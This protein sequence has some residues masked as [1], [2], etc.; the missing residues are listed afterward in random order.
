M[1]LLV[2]GQ[3]D[4]FARLLQLSDH[5]PAWMIML[6][7]LL[8]IGTLGISFSRYALWLILVYLVMCMFSGNA[9]RQLDTG[10]TLMRWWL[11]GC[12][13]LASLHKNAHPGRV[14]IMLGTY[15]L[16]S[17]VSLLWSPNFGAG[18]QIS[19]LSIA[20]ILFAGSGISGLLP[21]F[22]TMQKIPQFYVVASS[23][24]AINAIIGFGN[25]EGGRR[26]SGSSAETVSASLF[27]ITGG[28]LMPS[29]I[30]GYNFYK[31]KRR[32]F[33]LIGFAV[34]FGLCFLSGQRTG[35]YAGIAGSLAFIFQINAKMIPRAIIL[36][37]SAIFFCLTL[38]NYF[39][40]QASFI[41][42]RTIT[43]SNT[44]AFS[45]NFNTTGRAE[46]WNSFFEDIL[47]NPI[48]GYGASADKVRGTM[49][50]HN[51][52]LQEWYN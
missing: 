48:I 30:W 43:V 50:A 17:L 44:N 38:A 2:L 28:L 4:F 23:V 6:G 33:S 19:C 7:A 9:I 42:E 10:S 41:F 20:M 5:F 47:D 16:F 36:S 31:G 15:W 52:Y 45:L 14:C 32:L 34:V 37:L 49:G 8:L 24:F 35:F 29:L 18:I 21:D 12:L 22:N 27:V 46:L 3:N 1:D 39:P 26:F 13:S 25:I 40:S 11:I 51:A